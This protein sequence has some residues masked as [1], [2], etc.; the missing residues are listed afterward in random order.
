MSVLAWILACAGIG[1]TMVLALATHMVTR[2]RSDLGTR[3]FAGVFLGGFA[4]VCGALIPWATVRSFGFTAAAFLS[5]LERRR[6][7]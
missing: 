1:S 2:K 4:F 7:T 5:A 6:A 3:L